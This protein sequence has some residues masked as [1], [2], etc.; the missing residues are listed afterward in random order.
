MLMVK[1]G[2]VMVGAAVRD[3]VLERICVSPCGLSGYTL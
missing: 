2:A 3:Q 1:P